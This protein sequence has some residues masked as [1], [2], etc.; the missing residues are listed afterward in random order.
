MIANIKPTR[1]SEAEIRSLIEGSMHHSRSNSFKSATCLE[2]SSLG[3]EHLI[4]KP[5]PFLQTELY[6]DGLVESQS[7]IGKI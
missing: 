6:A 3:S 4:H 7:L 1:G 5:W 2:K